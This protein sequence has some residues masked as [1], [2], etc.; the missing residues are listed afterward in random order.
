M[1]YD[2]KDVFKIVLELS[3]KNTPDTKFHLRTNNCN[4]TT[5]GGQVSCQI[6]Y[7]SKGVQI[8]YDSKD[9]FKNVLHLVC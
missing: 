4:N 9:V 1:I 7:D 5:V 6:I 3:L 2:S 8:I